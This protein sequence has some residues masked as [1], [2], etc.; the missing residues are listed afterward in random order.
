[1]K[2]GSQGLILTEADLNALVDVH[3][4]EGLGTLELMIYRMPLYQISQ[5]LTFLVREQINLLLT[6]F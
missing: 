2:E 1:M 5:D 3:D 6:L 4:L